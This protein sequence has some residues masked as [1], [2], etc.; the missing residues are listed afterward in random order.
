MKSCVFGTL[1]LVIFLSYIHPGF[2]ITTLDDDTYEIFVQMV[3][4]EFTIPVKERTAQQ[5]AA[6]VRFWRNKDKLSLQGGMLC[7]EGKP[8]VKKSSLKGVVKKCFK[9]SKG[10]GT[11]NPQFIRNSMLASKIAQGFVRFA[12]EIFRYDTRST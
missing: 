4:G 3:K 5:N 11:R 2:G 6:R 9:K 10:S 1:F 7:F 12:H 8:I